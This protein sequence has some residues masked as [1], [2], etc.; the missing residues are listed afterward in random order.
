MMQNLVLEMV[1]GEGFSESVL[2]FLE[3]VLEFSNII[4]RTT[5]IP[6]VKWA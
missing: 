6:A 5:L 4:R 2:G 3:L 1:P